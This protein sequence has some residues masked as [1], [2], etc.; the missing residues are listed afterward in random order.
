MT[1]SR[2]PAANTICYP[3]YLARTQFASDVGSRK[4]MFNGIGGCIVQTVKRQDIVFLDQGYAVMCG[5]AFVYHGAQLGFF[6]QLA[7]MNLIINTFYSNTEIFLREL[8][9]NSSDVFDNIRHDKIKSTN[10]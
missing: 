7:K 5:G 10:T 8:I 6:S 2:T 9:S 3:F 4:K 1:R